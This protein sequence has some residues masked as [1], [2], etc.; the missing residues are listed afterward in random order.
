[1]IEKIEN[2]IRVNKIK[3]VL[4]GNSEYLIIPRDQS[5][6]GFQGFDGVLLIFNKF[7]KEHPE[8][9]LEEKYSQTLLEL[10]GSNSEREVIYGIKCALY[11]MNIEASTDFKLKNE[12]EIL[13]AAKNGLARKMSEIQDYMCRLTNST[14]GKMN[15]EA[16]AQELD[17]GIARMG[18]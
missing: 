8:F 17:K 6:D 13:Q 10:L 5:L 1:M 9:G 4:L 15:F 11:H 7:N 16:I 2:A 14:E 12:R 18:M 3:E